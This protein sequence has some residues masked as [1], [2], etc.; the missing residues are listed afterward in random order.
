VTF[1][2]ADGAQL[3][4]SFTGVL[5]PA[6]PTQG[7]GHA[8]FTWTGGTGRFAGATGTT[9]FTVD[10]NLTDGSFTF[11]SRGE[12]SV[13]APAAGPAADA[14]SAVTLTASGERVHQ[15]FEKSPGVQ[16]HVISTIPDGRSSLGN[17]TGLSDVVVKGAFVEGTLIMT[18]D[19]GSTLELSFSQ[20]WSPK[21]GEFGGDESAF[22]V[23]GG[24]GRFEG[25]TGGGTITA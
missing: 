7:L 25:A 3:R 8:T 22:V 14:A 16:A 9:P 24:T 17:W 10:Q 21:V 19:D 12:I 1:T 4:G 15:S 20:K 23:T 2:A 18:F 11:S 5:T 13:G 6:S